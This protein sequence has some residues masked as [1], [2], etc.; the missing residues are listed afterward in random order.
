MR[1]LHNKFY[2]NFLRI[3]FFKSLYFLSLLCPFP[4]LDTGHS[5]SF[6]QVRVSCSLICSLIWCIIELLF[7]CSEFAKNESPT[8]LS[9]IIDL[10]LYALF[11]FLLRIALTDRP[12]IYFV[13]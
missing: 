3:C 6:S 1:S 9:L 12:L 5:M 2:I 13:I 8:L 7:M 11:F 4:R 10:I